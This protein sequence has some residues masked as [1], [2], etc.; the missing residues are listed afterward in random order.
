PGSQ[1]PNIA[2]DIDAIFS[3]P[4]FRDL[5]KVQQSFTGIG[6][7]RPL[8][9]NLAYKGQALNGEGLL[10]SGSYFNVLGIQP[11]LGRLIGPG[12]DRNAG[13]P[14]VAVLSYAYWQ[15]RFAGDP[16]ILNT[17]LIVNGQPLTI[18]GV[19]PRDFEG[20]AVTSRPQVFVPITLM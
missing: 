6:A 16:G 11:A 1:L 19:A 7:H 17:T 20:T 3:Y 18:V 8:D 13:E 12:D 9:V 2:G 10:V 15:T 5:E 14:P 4:M